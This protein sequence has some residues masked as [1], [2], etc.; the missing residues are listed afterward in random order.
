MGLWNKIAEAVFGPSHQNTTFESGSELEE[1]VG[2]LCTT[3]NADN[4]EQ[5]DYEA[6]VEKI[7]AEALKCQCVTDNPTVKPVA[8]YSMSEDST[9]TKA[10]LL[11]ERDQHAGLSDRGDWYYWFLAK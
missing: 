3:G 6:E 7:R 11:W 9:R 10:Y 8:D 4:Y 5:F 1:Q 2:P